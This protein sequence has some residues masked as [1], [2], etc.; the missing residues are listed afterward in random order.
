MYYT[1]EI[2]TKYFYNLM[3]LSDCPHPRVKNNYLLL[4]KIDPYQICSG[5]TKSRGAGMQLLFPPYKPDYDVN[6]WANR[7]CGKRYENRIL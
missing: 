6:H 2:V 4:N 3:F 1:V 7:K 5:A